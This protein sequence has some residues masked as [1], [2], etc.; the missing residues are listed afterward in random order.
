[1]R[2]ITKKMVDAVEWTV[3]EIKLGAGYDFIGMF[4]SD[5][6]Y[7]YKK[8]PYD[9]MYSMHFYVSDWDISTEYEGF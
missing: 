5:T 2:K 4:V 6:G 1:M 8:T 3:E 9:D 7:I